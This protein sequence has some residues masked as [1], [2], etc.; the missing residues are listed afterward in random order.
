M[1]HKTHAV[2]E[3]CQANLCFWENEIEEY[4]NFEVETIKTGNPAS[5]H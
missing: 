1:R 2:H 5:S 3:D 4:H